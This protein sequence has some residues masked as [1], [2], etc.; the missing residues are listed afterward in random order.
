MRRPLRA[1]ACLGGLAALGITAATLPI[2]PT[3]APAAPAAQETAREPVP[4]PAPASTADTAGDT[5]GTGATDD[6]DDRDDTADTCRVVAAKPVLDARGVIRA[7][8]GRS[9]CDERA[10]L[11]VR[12]KQVVVGPDR[13]VKSGSRVLSNGR[14]TAT[15]PCSGDR[16]RYYTTA[17]DYE[18]G[19]GTSPT[20]TLS[21][22]RAEPRPTPRTDSRTEPRTDSRALTPRTGTAASAAEAQVVALTNRARA[23]NGCRPL[24]HDPKLRVAAERHSADMAARDY[25]DHTSPDGRSPGDR[26]EAAGLATI[27]A[28]AENISM[29]QRSAAEAVT[30]WLD[31][32]GHRANILNCA[33][34]HIGVGH[35]P[36]GPYW[37]QVFA[38][39]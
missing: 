17:L 24:V 36:A 35:D 14:I 7:T 12:I 29:G 25:F 1:L 31:S 18:G 16:A 27:R 5:G 8:A 32:P 21:C 19:T 2:W 13:T 37:T 6:T 34:T 20:V 15:L 23:Q 4:R 28:W 26:I 22:P 10:R 39:R 9:G 3:D 11:R 38:A 30:G 33:F